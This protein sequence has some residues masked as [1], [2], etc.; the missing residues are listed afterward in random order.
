MCGY[1]RVFFE[2]NACDHRLAMHFDVD[3]PPI[4]KVLYD[5][6]FDIVERPL[7]L[8]EF[9][10]SWREHPPGPNNRRAPLWMCLVTNR[11]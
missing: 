8:P 7:D 11:A 1:L 10:E 6:H 2:N 5:G 9:D 4:E 3:F